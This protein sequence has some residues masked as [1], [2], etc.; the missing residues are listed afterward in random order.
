MEIFVAVKLQQ[1]KA[2]QEQVDLLEYIINFNN[3]ARSKNKDDK[4]N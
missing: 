3:K 2:D 4:K 1:T